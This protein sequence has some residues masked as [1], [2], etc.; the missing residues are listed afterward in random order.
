MLDR[1]SDISGYKGFR[2]VIKENG[3]LDDTLSNMQR[4]A[5]RDFGQVKDLAAELDGESVKETSKNIWNYLREH[6][7]YKLD[8]TGVEEL[9]TPARSLF[10]GKAGK[11][12][13]QYGIDCDD[14]T[15]LV[16]AFLLNLGIEHEYRVTAY[17]EKGVFEHIYPVAFDAKGNEYVIDL[18]PEI[19]HFNFE[20][21]PIID[22]KT[23]NMKIEEL[24]GFADDERSELIEELNEPFTLDGMEDD[25][26]IL[27][28]LFLSGIGEVETEE[29]AEIVL[30]GA[31]DVANLLENGILAEI[32]KAKNSLEDE[33]KS[34]SVLSETLNVNEE[35]ESIN[36]ILED[37]DD[38]EQ[39]MDTIRDV[40]NSNS[41]Y[42]N[43]FK[44]ILLSLTKLDTDFESL[45]GFDDEPI[46][47]ARVDFG[48]PDLS[49]II[50]ENDSLQGIFNRKNKSTTRKR[51]LRNFVKKIGSGVKKVVKAVVKYNPAS[52]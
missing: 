29:E 13:Q 39:R 28:G 8:K 27:D 11:G 41:S 37:W 17:K 34:P 20:A 19:P 15:I 14:Y 16:S 23:I 9:R 12:N 52:I 51:P 21:K 7:N 44:A 38:E 46:Y 26:V 33:M 22:L 24:S 2:R 31:E 10:D 45:G 48:E 25:D 4:I 50:E 40:I 42:S 5:R 6:T 36:S 18:V 43:F 30:S 47:L 35:I 32:V 3:N 1:T 49:E